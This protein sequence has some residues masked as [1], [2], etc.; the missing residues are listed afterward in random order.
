MPCPQRSPMRAFLHPLSIL[1]R[2]PALLLRR[3][4]TA[5][6]GEAD[7]C[8][9][10]CRV[11]SFLC[12]VH[13]CMVEWWRRSASSQHRT[14]HRY[15]LVCVRCWPTYNVRRGCVGLC[16][17]NGL[18]FARS[19]GAPGIYR[20]PAIGPSAKVFDPRPPFPVGQHPARTEVCVR[21]PVPLRLNE[22]TKPV[23]PF[24]Y[25]HH[26]SL[27]ERGLPQRRAGVPTTRGAD[28]NSGQ[29]TSK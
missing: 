9:S 17:V 28:A 14:K 5:L 8:V 2:F 29:S 6:P 4:G 15:R 19:A 27:L 24:S 7:D 10:T 1:E 3:Q 21:V 12:P 20:M 13:S 22:H 25:V 18:R 11:G 26:A 16:E 23:V